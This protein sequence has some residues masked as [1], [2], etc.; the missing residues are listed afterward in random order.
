MRAYRYFCQRE[1]ISKCVPGPIR[2]GCKYSRYTIARGLVAPLS[3][4]NYDTKPNHRGLALVE[5]DVLAWM[6]G[7]CVVSVG[8]F[9]FNAINWKRF[10]L[11]H[12][13]ARH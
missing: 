7:M 13:I 9:L 8:L 3:L 5:T 1:A 12:F 6:F 10:L 2:S 11:L 4:F